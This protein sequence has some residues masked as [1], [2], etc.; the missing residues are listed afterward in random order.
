MVA[1]T[2]WADKDARHIFYLLRHWRC[3][4]S[5]SCQSRQPHSDKEV[6]CGDSQPGKESKVRGSVSSIAGARET[7][8]E[9]FCKFDALV[10]AL[11]P[12]ERIFC[13]RYSSRRLPLCL[14]SQVWPSAGPTLHRNL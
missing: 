7:L 12:G 13:C 14:V 2:G 3:G 5:I 10:F 9:S 11:P 1:G 6:V 4:P 8:A